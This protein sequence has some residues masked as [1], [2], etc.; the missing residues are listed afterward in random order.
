MSDHD[1]HAL[2]TISCITDITLIF[3]TKCFNLLPLIKAFL[4]ICKRL[5]SSYYSVCLWKYDIYSVGTKTCIL[6]THHT[7]L[8]DKYGK[9]Y[10]FTYK[11]MHNIT[12]SLVLL[13]SFSVITLVNV[14]APKVTTTDDAVLISHK[15]VWPII[16]CITNR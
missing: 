4:R 16:S 12:S 15:L 11:K 10:N 13:L 7:C 9:Y 2:S 5:G 6:G 1:L 3:Y 14:K 8:T